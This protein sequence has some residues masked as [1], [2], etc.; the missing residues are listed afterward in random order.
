MKHCHAIF[1]FD[2]IYGNKNKAF[3]TLVNRFFVFN[4]VSSVYRFFIFGN[5]HLSY[6]LNIQ[7]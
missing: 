6:F 4:L 2:G 3:F 5:S 1:Y 7:V